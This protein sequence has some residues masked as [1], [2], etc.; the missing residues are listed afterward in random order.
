MRIKITK[1]GIYGADGEIPVG[2]E[3]DVKSEPK[4]WDGRYEVIGK[5]EGKAEVNNGKYDDMKRDELD[6]LA[7][8]RGVD[9]SEAKNKGDVIAA[10]Q[11]ADEAAK[12]A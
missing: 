2:T 9:I 3:L 10:L 4:G 5:T 8:E 12:T 1:P 6:A 7:K 11:L